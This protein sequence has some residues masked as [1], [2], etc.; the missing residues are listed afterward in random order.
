[1]FKV[2]GSPPRSSGEEPAKRKTNP[3][4]LVIL[5]LL[6]LLGSGKA[7]PAAGSPL[8]NDPKQA[9]RVDAFLRSRQSPFPFSGSVLIAM[10]GN[11]VFDKAYGYAD[12]ELLVPN[13]PNTI[14]RI[15]S[16]TKPLTATAAMALVE[17]H[18]LSLDD[19]IC[20]YIANCPRAWSPVMVRHLLSHTSGIP[21]LF[22][23]VAA[24]PVEATREAIDKAIQSSPALALDSEPGSV[25]AYRN[26]NYMLLGY[27]LEAVT[28]K[29]WG[30]VL[31]AEV[32]SRA[33]MTHTAYDDVWAVVEGRARG[34]DVKGGRIRNIPYK[35]HSAYAA[36][37][38]HSTTHDLHAF[39]GA[40]S[41]GR[42]VAPVTAREMLTPQH[43][44][45]G[46]GWQIKNYFGEH[47]FNH[48]GGIDGFAS[49][50]AVYPDRHLVIVVLSNIESEPAKLTAC[51]IAAILLTPDHHPVT[52]CPEP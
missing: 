32:F 44:D 45:Y 41:A 47:M 12:Y 19:P 38:L 51:Q 16:L 34:Y 33:G 23:R 36:G 26:F 5:V 30:D 11:V 20:R 21:D 37:G 24:A 1:M 27:I 42:M 3:M 17:K 40:F 10:D 35:D 50:L 22:G 15:G 31:Q 52:S 29:H 9:E 48:S 13:S 7:S 49:H 28:G 6:G 14:F 43:G 46:Y 4:H 8:A 2:S 39:A 18:Q 25:Y